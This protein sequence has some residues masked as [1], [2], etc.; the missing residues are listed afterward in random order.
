MKLSDQE[1]VLKVIIYDVSG[2]LVSIYNDSP[3][4]IQQFPTGI[5]FLS[6]ITNVKKYNSKLV[7]K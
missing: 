6:I 2:K 1:K 4:N 5:Y 3:I 7:K